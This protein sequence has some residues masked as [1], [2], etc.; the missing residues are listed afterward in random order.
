MQRLYQAAQSAAAAGPVVEIATKSG[1]GIGDGTESKRDLT[2]GAPAADRSVTDSKSK[3]EWY[4]QY[5]EQF[6]ATPPAT[7]R[8]LWVRAQAGVHE[9]RVYSGAGDCLYHANWLR[10][11]SYPTAPYGHFSEPK[12]Y[13]AQLMSNVVQAFDLSLHMYVADMQALVADPVLAAQVRWHPHISWSSLLSPTLQDGLARLLCCGAFQDDNARMV[14]ELRQAVL[15]LQK[16]CWV[17][18]RCVTTMKKA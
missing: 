7:L 16:N 9:M 13:L 15:L 12:L 1:E 18:L 5:V 4:R 11:G 17:R 14:I 3:D 10:D 2:A 6:L 8:H